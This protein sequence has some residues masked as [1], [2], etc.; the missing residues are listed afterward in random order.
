MTTLIEICNS[1]Q[2]GENEK[3]IDLIRTLDMRDV[4]KEIELP[5]Y[6]GRRLLHVIA[7]HGSLEM[8]KIL[9][10]EKHA[11]VNIADDDEM[12]PLCDSFVKSRNDVSIFLI[13]NGA[14][15]VIP[16]LN[17]WTP[18]NFIQDLHF[19]KK[20]VKVFL[21][22]SFLND[23]YAVT[24]LE[25]ALENFNQESNKKKYIFIRNIIL[26]KNLYFLTYLCFT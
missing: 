10:L 9:V 12:T 25:K 14:D 6:R 24:V 2:F 7:W 18:L 13:E 20:M 5:N 1:I 15:I 11:N 19:F 8:C 21:K 3:A 23:K 16:I 26:F 4:N 22:K 17:K